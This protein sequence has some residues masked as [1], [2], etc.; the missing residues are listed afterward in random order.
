MTIDALL[1]WCF[2]QGITVS[3]GDVGTDWGR[4]YRA[5]RSIVLSRAL[6]QRQRLP[7]LLHEIAHAAR[8][9]DGHQPERIERRINEEVSLTLI[10]PRAYVAAEER[11]GWSTGAIAAELEL[12]RW[13]VQAYRRVLARTAAA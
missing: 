2:E 3:I 5:R 6:S 7:V 8:G 9:D 13:V 1:E 11:F 10:D 4:Y 12:P